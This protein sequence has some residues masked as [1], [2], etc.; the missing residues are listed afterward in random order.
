[1]PGAG[2]IPGHLVEAAMLAHINA[3]SRTFRIVGPQVKGLACGDVGIGAM[4][5]VAELVNAVTELL[6][7]PVPAN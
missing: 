5:D 7:P 2:H 6:A 3:R 4:A 1:M